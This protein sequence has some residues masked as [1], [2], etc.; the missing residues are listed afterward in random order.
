MRNGDSTMT[1]AL[2]FNQPLLSKQ[3]LQI[4]NKRTLKYG[5]G[6]AEKDYF[7]AVVSKIIYDSE[8]KNK[9]IF[10]GGTAIHHCCSTYSA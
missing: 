6:I 7:L 5:L 4:I 2:L 10:K 9:I 3:Q 8:L 1:V